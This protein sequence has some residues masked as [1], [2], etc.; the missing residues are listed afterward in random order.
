MQ[1]K[2][3]LCG[4]DLQ[5]K[6]IIAREMFNSFFHSLFSGLQPSSNIVQNTF[7]SHNNQ[8]AT[9]NTDL[10]ED[11]T[12]LNLSLLQNATDTIIDNLSEDSIT[13]ST[14]DNHDGN[15]RH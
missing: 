7:A 3:K 11:R 2:D 10:S 12:K 15:C 13:S 14:F 4:T 5:N 1:N 6:N 8:L 9:R